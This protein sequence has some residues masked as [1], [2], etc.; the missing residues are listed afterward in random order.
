MHDFWLSDQN[1]RLRYTS[2]FDDFENSLHFSISDFPIFY[3]RRPIGLILCK[4]KTLHITSSSP[5]AMK[6]E[7]L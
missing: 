1:Y 3:H 5:W 6:N 4:A 7:G 2:N